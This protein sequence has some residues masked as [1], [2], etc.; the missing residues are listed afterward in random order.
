MTEEFDWPAIEAAVAQRLA[1]EKTGKR[2]TPAPRITTRD[3]IEQAI[4]SGQPADQTMREL[5]VTYK[6]YRTVSQALDRAARSA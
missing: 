1:D 2:G 3:R 6:A 5:D 4:A